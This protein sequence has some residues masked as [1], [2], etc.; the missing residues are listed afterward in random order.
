MKKLLRFA[1]LCA[2]LLA[3]V[4][5]ILMMAGDAIVHDYELLGKVHDFY[6]G[7]VVLFGNGNACVASIKGT[8]EDAKAAW[9]AVLAFIF[10]IIALVALIVSSLMVFV[11]IKALEK[12]GGIIALAAGGLLLVAGIFLFFTVPAFAAA[13]DWNLD[14]YG[15]GAAWVVSAILAIVAGIVSALPAVLA[16][17]EKK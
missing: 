1:P 16:I 2:L 7:T 6:G 13:N 12:F 14:K 3:I 17:V 9:N 10:L 8:I 5:F 4:A 15:L 11:K